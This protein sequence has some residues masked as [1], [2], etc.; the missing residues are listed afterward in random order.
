MV[1]GCLCGTACGTSSGETYARRIL[2]SRT[3]AFA[4]SG[5]C[6]KTSRRPTSIDAMAEFERELIRE[7]VRA[8]LRNAKAKEKKL[9]GPKVKVDSTELS[10]LWAQGLGWKKI[11]AQLGVGFGTVRRAAQIER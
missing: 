4:R 9:G 10:A 6:R 11:A 8:G 3:E 2:K 1:Q 5:N 7:R